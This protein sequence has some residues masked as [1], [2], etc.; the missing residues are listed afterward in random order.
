MRAGAGS[1]GVSTDPYGNVYITGETQSEVDISTS[2]AYQTSLR[3]IQN[4]YIAKFNTNGNIIW[5]TYFGGNGIEYANAIKTDA[6]GNVFIDG[7]SESDSGIATTGAYQKALSGVRDALIAKF[8]EMG[9]LI[10]ATYFGGTRS[11]Q[12]TDLSIDNKGNVYIAGETESEDGIATSGAFQ[13]KKGS[14]T[15]GFISKFNNG[16]KLLWSTY[17]GGNFDCNGLRIKNDQLGNVFIACQTYGSHSLTTKGAF[18]SYYGGGANDA[19]I[20]KFD[21]VGNQ[22]WAT[23]YG[24]DGYDMPT[25]ICTDLTGNVYFT[26]LTTSSQGI[27]TL[28][29]YQTFY[30]GNSDIF[31][32]KFTN[33]GSLVWS[34]YYGGTSDDQSFG[35]IIDHSNNLFVSG[36]TTSRS[37][38]TT[39]Y[40][41]QSNY[42]ATYGE[43]FLA[44]FDRFGK[45]LRGTYYGGDCN[46][47]VNG[48]CADTTGAIYLTGITCSKNGI[49]TSGA[50]ETSLTDPPQSCF[51]AKFFIKT[52]KYDA[53]ILNSTVA[54]TVCKVFQ[55]M[56]AGIV[57]KN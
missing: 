48:I 10:W 12:A 36:G 3:G 23:Y 18:Q 51:L 2:G 43:S 14:E 22:I 4:V 47:F 11:E 28:G 39:K 8:S 25:S 21:S 33:A 45:L 38:I 42:A 41:Y 44:K 30:A 52:F 19:I 50:F 9:I 32:A 27:A 54:D 1:G 57:I 15:N 13:T 24:G 6:D 26:G 49:A 16:G 31:I 35:L 5:A 37:G 55:R 46:Q 56:S 20:T 40:E 53:G 34:T 17:Y 7:L 29:S